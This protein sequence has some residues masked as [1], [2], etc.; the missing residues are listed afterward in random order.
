MLAHGLLAFGKDLRTSDRRN[1]VEVAASF[2]ER[3]EVAGRARYLFPAERDGQPV[4]PHPH[5]LVK[6]FL[7][8]GVDRARRLRAGDG[9]VI[10]LERLLD[11]AYAEVR[12]PSTDADWYSAS[13]WLAALEMDL[14][15]RAGKQPPAGLDLARLRAAALSR[16]EAD[17]APLATLARD[18]FPGR[19]PLN[20][21]AEDMPMGLAKRN[22]TNIYGHPCGGL[23]FVQAVLRSVAASG[24]GDLV[25]RAG[26][27][28]RL[29][30]SRYEAERALYA[31]TLRTH[32][33]AALLVS[34][35]QLK[36]FGHL[37]ETLALVDEL[38]LLS[39]D[40]DLA[41]DVRRAR[42]TAVA[43]LLSVFEVLKR[44][45]A[46]DRLG[47]LSQRQHQLVLDLIGDGCHAAHGLR[48]TLPLLDAR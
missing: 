15:G 3:Q 31:D 5:L 36:F 32:P 28:V 47:E 43:D 39:H 19:P 7:E 12:E 33:T 44:E 23:H 13:W 24:Q 8:V 46:Y 30:L 27:Q 17:D 45:H 34:G 38:G 41:D 11:D 22:K 29:L 21:F 40:T 1:A 20:P 10:T 6:T 26:R 37:L 18:G 4:E 9:T 25:A 2:S 14:A 48:A 35:Q 42:R 16:L